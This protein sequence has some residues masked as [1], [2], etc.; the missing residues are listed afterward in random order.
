MTMAKKSY[1]PHPRLGMKVVPSKTDYDRRENRYT[2]EEYLDGLEATND[3]CSMSNLEK[4]E[5]DPVNEFEADAFFTQE[6]YEYGFHIEIPE[7]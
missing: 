5:N 7:N 2:I 3:E 6:M 4:E 1:E